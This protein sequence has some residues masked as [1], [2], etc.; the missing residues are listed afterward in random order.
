MNKPKSSHTCSTINMAPVYNFVMGLPT[1]IGRGKCRLSLSALGAFI[2]IS[3]LLVSCGKKSAMFTDADRKVADSIVRAVRTTD[4]LALLQ[5]RMESEGGILGSIVALR[6]WGKALRNESRFEEALCAHSEGLRQAEAIGDTIEWVQAL[7]NI[8]TDYRRMGVLDVAQEY[9]YWAWV[10][11]E[12]CADTSFTAKKNRVVSLNGLGNIY[13]T[14]GNYERA[15]SVLRMALKGERELDSAL[16]LAINYANLGSIF[17]HR[18]QTDSAWVYYRRSMVLNMEAGNDL[19]ISLCHTYFGSLYEKAQ[20]Y[21]KATEEYQTAYRLMQASKDEWHAL[22]SLIALAGIYHTTG[23][24]T[25]AMEYLGR[26]R[27]MA[28]SIKSPE[29]LAEIYT[30]YYKH[31]KQAGDC[32]SALASYE[33]AAAMRDS[34]LDMEKV[35]RIQ[36]TSLNI[37]RNRQERETNGMKLRLEQERVAKKTGYIVFG[38]MIVSLSGLVALLLYIQRIRK[39]NHLTLKRL[40][41]LRENFFTNITHEFRTPLTV[42]LGLSHHLQATDAAE[43]RDKAQTIERQGNGLLML[44]NQLLDISKIKS[45]V[46]NADWKRGNIT[47]HL[48]MIMESY[49]DYARNRNIDLQFFGKEAVE[50]DF[51]PDYVN[52]VMN[53]LLSNAFKFTPEYGKVSVAAWRE[54]ERLFIDVEDTGRG[55]DNETLAHVFEPFYQ[56]EGNARNIGTGVGLALVKQIMDAVEGTIVAE[57][58]AG[59]GTTFHISMPIRNEA[60]QIADTSEINTPLLPETETTLADSG[61]ENEQCRLLII[62]DNR[63]IAAYIGS[64]FAGRYAVSY[65]A[66]G[67]E[68]LEKAQKLVPDLIITDLMMPGMDGLEVCRQVRGN[69]ITDHIPIIVVTAKITEEE[70]ICGLEAG[71]DAYLAKPFNAGELRTR[72]EK[73]LEGRRLLREKY[74]QIMV[75]HQDHEEKE[76]MQKNAAAMRFLAK[77]SDVIYLQL[78]RGKEI[79]VS[80]IAS[81]M[82]MSDRQFYR[83]IHALTNSTPTVYIQRIKIKKAKSLLDGNSQMSFGEIADRCGFNDYSNFVRTFKNACGVTPTEYRR[84]NAG[85]V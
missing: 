73:L 4:S 20:Q 63:D 3:F 62:E 65:A 1:H 32:R 14:L 85:K 44:I 42:I 16:G 10:L 19:G 56:G 31:Y 11:S 27:Q 72:V 25:K 30:L 77:V 5:K 12:E 39:R 50:M 52:K 40:S 17:E 36:N 53:N 29:H 24:S 48:T 64:Q 34:V 7:N 82:C 2:F 28:E 75:V 74:A 79:E 80:Q 66:N 45:A 68:G 57:S 60:K 38:I 55:M 71:A 61:G 37:E 67:A 26:A 8:G 58:T 23:S 46:G 47:A 33:Q 59:R 69:E 49:R 22:N 41:S 6:E 21:D 84:S 70:R 78:N 15:D 76:A 51:V 83:K 13:L 54:D 18:G 9:H 81:A 43:V 35:N